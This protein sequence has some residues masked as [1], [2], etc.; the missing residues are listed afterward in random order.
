M[1]IGW[2]APSLQWMNMESLPKA[3][4]WKFYS[5][6]ICVCAAWHLGM[7]RL[8]EED[9]PITE[10]PGQSICLNFARSLKEAFSFCAAHWVNTKKIKCKCSRRTFTFGNPPHTRPS[11]SVTVSVAPLQLSRQ[12]RRTRG[13]RS[14]PE[15]TRPNQPNFR[16]EH[17]MLRIMLVDF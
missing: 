14:A 10:C 11:R 1:Q 16:V 5:P 15:T 8:S 2:V 17:S 9:T 3:F 7:V 13:S 12:L 6:S 4:G